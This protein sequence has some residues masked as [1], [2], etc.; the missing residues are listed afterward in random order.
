ML[1]QSY[2]VED[3][4]SGGPSYV[5]FL[6]SVHRQIQHKLNLNW[7]VSLV[8]PLFRVFEILDLEEEQKKKE[9]QIFFLC[10]YF[11]LETLIF[12]LVLYSMED[13]ERE[14]TETEWERELDIF[15][16]FF[17]YTTVFFVVLLERLV[18][19]YL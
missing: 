18:F 1:F 15:L 3:R 19:Q 13:I 10:T 2:M 11:R 5:D 9:R 4:G 8:S 6:I 12:I 17:I 16:P 14:R 7:Q